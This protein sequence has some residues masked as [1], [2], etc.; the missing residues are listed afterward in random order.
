MVVLQDNSTA[1]P[2]IDWKSVSAE[3]IDETD[4]LDY[5]DLNHVP[6]VVVIGKENNNDIQSITKF[7]KDRNDVTDNQVF[8]LID[9]KLDKGRVGSIERKPYIL[10]GR[11]ISQNARNETLKRLKAVAVRCDSQ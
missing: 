2:Y 9:D 5:T 10:P 3:R 7:L 4:E 1:L 8:F 11:S 6:I